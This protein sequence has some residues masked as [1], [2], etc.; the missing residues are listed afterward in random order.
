[1]PA[2]RHRVGQV[3]SNLLSNAIK[4]TRHGGRIAVSAWH[5]DNTIVVS[6]SD[7]G[8]GILR[9]D[10]PKVFDRFWQAEKT[11]RLGTG[12][13]LSIAKGIVEAHG[14]KIWVNSQLGKGSSFSFTLPL[15]TLDTKRLDS[16]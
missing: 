8:P 9:E 3:L 16:A 4:F 13:G 11:K 10:L 15:V 14:G 5:R 12:L 6:V 1:L 7:E 2:D